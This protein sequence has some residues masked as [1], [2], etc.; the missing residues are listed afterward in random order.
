MFLDQVPARAE[1][2]AGERGLPLIWRA[3]PAGGP[4]G[5]D[6]VSEVAFTTTGLHD[7]PWSPAHL[8]VQAREDGGFDLGWIPRSRIDGDRW[9]GA[10]AADPM[11][12]RVRVLDGPVE[13][14]A[15]EGEGS[16]NVYAAADVAADFP[17]GLGDDAMVGVAQWGEGY[18]WGAETRTGLG[19]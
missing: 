12:F 13:V 1:S 14:R 18:G 19:G 11:R 9:D 10:A 2:P 5:G 4:A 15:F 6:G 3:G 17:G 7:R 16:Q 8:R